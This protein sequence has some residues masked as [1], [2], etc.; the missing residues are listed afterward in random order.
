MANEMLNLRHLLVNDSINSL[1]YILKFLGA[2]FTWN[3]I[4]NF[5][6]T[7]LKNFIDCVI[8]FDELDAN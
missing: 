6:D 4:D 7:K 1:T 8:M 2:H 3:E 5:E